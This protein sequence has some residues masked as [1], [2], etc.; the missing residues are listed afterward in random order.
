MEPIET[1]K[2]TSETIVVVEQTIPI[3][4]VEAVMTHKESKTCGRFFSCLVG[5]WSLLLNSCE[6]V[7]KGLSNCCLCCSSVFLGCNKCLEQMDCDGH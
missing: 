3:E 1:E 7:C 2:L 6:C 5:T 4:A